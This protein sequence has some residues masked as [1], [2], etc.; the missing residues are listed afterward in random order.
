[1]VQELLPGLPALLVLALVPVPVLALVWLCAPVRLLA[2]L[3]VFLLA[4]LPDELG[5]V[6]ALAEL[7]VPLCWGWQQWRLCRTAPARC[8]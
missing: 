6:A 8:C 4:L 5:V 3:L 2:F 1:M 7:L